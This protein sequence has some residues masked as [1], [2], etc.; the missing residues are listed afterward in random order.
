MKRTTF[1][2]PLFLLSPSLFAQTADRWRVS[3]LRV[4]HGFGATMAYAPSAVWDVEA[5]VSE[6]SYDQPVATFAVGNIPTTEVRHYS[7]HPID[8]F[9]TRHFPIGSRVAAFL[10]AGARYVKAPSEWPR[11]YFVS[12]LP[13][14]RFDGFAHRASAQAGGGVFLRL[15]P[16]AAV[17]AEVT[18]LIRSDDTRFDPLIRAA[19]GLAW[20]F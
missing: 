12:D 2:L 9:V 4:Q 3:V 11:T 1:L 17:R 19:A 16:H 14:T 15:T 7:E 5:G 6:Q 10:H 18:R 20:R 13:T 8:L